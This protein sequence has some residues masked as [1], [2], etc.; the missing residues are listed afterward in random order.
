MSGSREH[1]RPVNA[2]P[3]SPLVQAKVLVTLQA[4]FYIVIGWFCQDMPWGHDISQSRVF[5]APILSNADL[6]A[7]IQGR[8]S[9]VVVQAGQVLFR[10]GP[11][12]S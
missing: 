3:E 12:S 11:Q 9:L 8:I 7:C 6:V 5:L 2:T 4:G 10:Y 1:P